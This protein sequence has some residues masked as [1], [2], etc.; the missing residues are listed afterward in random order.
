MNLLPLVLKQ[1]A[2]AFALT[3]EF[4]DQLTFQL[5]IVWNLDPVN[6]TLNPV[7]TYT[8]TVLGV[9]YKPK[10]QRRDDS[11]GYIFTENICVQQWNTTMTPRPGVKDRVLETSTGIIRQIMSVTQ[12][13]ARAIWIFETRIPTGQT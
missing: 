2:Y 12:D 9:V 8:K 11:G 5:Q 3:Q 1:T 7:P 13:P 10:I 4:Q 6:D